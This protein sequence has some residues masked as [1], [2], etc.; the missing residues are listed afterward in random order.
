MKECIESL[1]GAILICTCSTS[2]KVKEGNNVKEYVY[3]NGDITEEYQMLGGF[4]QYSAYS[5][6]RKIG[7]A[8]VY[9]GQSF[10]IFIAEDDT[11]VYNLE[12]M[13]NMPDSIITGKIYHGSGITEIKEMVNPLCM[14]S[15]CYEKEADFRE[16]II[17]IDSLRSDLF[18]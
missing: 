12:E 11:L 3:S 17:G 18:D 1:L 4:Y 14:N 2:C 8:N 15:V 6:F 10:L 9:H 13:N 7:A 5:C 16:I